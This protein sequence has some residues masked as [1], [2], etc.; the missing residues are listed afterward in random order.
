MVIRS[1]AAFDLADRDHLLH[2]VLCLHVRVGA[3][4]SFPTRRARTLLFWQLAFQFERAGV[5]FLYSAMPES[6]SLTLHSPHVSP[7]SDTSIY[8]TS[9]KTD[10]A[11]RSLM[12]AQ[13]PSSSFFFRLTSTL[14]AAVVRGARQ[15]KPVG[16][17]ST[18]QV[19]ADTEAAWIARD[20]GRQIRTSSFECLQTLWFLL[21]RLPR[22]GSSASCSCCCQITNIASQEKLRGVIK[23]QGTRIRRSA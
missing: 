8:C 10:P 12:A 16:V 17:Q 15:T 22:G 19:C 14:A 9:K 21:E 3:S 6:S 2:H 7:K 4:L 20:T 11:K 5:Y 1:D 18:P 13:T 23:S